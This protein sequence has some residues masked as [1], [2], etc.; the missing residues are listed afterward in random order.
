[1]LTFISIAGFIF[2]TVTALNAKYLL[3][4]N[5]SATQ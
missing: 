5:L 4:S 1:M 3:L 2:V